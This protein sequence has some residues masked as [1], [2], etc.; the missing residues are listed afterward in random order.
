MKTISNTIKSISKQVK[1]SVKEIVIKLKFKKIEKAIEFDKAVANLK[2]YKSQEADLKK[3]IAPL[4]E[5]IKEESKKAFLALFKQEKENPNTFWIETEK[6]GHRVMISPNDSYSKIDKDQF[7]YLNATYG[8]GT[9]NDTT[10]IVFDRDLF[11]KYEKEF[12]T[13]IKN[14]KVIKEEHKDLLIKK[15]HSFEV[16]KGSINKILEKKDPA[17]FLT[18]IDP[19][20]QIKSIQLYGQKD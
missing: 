1:T 4:N 18:D 6:D 15:E 17:G 10:K 7:L 9:A 16:A 3:K 8:V 2:K 12:T 19:T 11:K 20:F 13:L 5:L 14:S